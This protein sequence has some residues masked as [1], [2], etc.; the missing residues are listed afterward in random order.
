[1]RVLTS[2]DAPVDDVFLGALRRVPRAAAAAAALAD[3]VRTEPDAAAPREAQARAL[4]LQ[5]AGFERL[6][7]WCSD[8]LRR[9]P[10][11]GAA[12][13]PA[14][15]DALLGLAHDAERARYVAI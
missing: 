4:A 10:M 12:P 15:T 11:R 1:M 13:T 7:T 3:A 2:P 6:G 8:A 5:Q 9:L 14:L